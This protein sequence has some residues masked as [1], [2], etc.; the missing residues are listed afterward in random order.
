M[1]PTK[2]TKLKYQQAQ[3]STTPSKTENVSCKIQHKQRKKGNETD[4]KNGVGSR[5][6]RGTGT[7]GSV[8]EKRTKSTELST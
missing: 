5:D 1:A 8:K 3:K 4:L 6:E 7:A 2:Q